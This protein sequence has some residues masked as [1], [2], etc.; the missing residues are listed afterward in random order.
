MFAVAVLGLPGVAAAA[1]CWDDVPTDLDGGGPDVVFGLPSYDLPGKPNAGAIVVFSNL[2]AK[3]AADPKSPSARTLLTADDFDG[4]E[5]QAGA[6]FGAAVSAWHDIADG[7]D[8]DDCSDLL[9]GAPGQ[10][11]LGQTG[12]GQVYW[13]GGSESGLGSLKAVYDETMAGAGGPEPGDGFGSTI[14]ANSWSTVAI[15]VPGRDV[16]ELEDAGRVIRLNWT[17]VDTDP[18]LAV[19]EQD[20]DGDRN[21]EAG[22]RFGEVLD[23][24]A[25]GDGDLL[26]VGIPHED[27]GAKVDAGAVELFSTTGDA[28]SMVTQSS[29]GAGGAAEAG[30][31]YGASVAHWWTFVNGPTARLAVGVPGEDIGSTVDAGMVSFATWTMPPTPEEPMPALEGMAE[32]QHQ[33]SPASQGPSRGATVMAPACWPA[34]SARTTVASTSS[35]VP[36]TRASARRGPPVRLSQ[37]EFETDASPSTGRNGLSWTQNSPGVAGNGETGDRFAARLSSVELTTP[38]DDTDLVWPVVLLTVPGEDVEGVVDAGMAYIG[39]APG[40]VSVP[41]NLPRQAGAGIGMVPMQ[42]FLF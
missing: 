19:V 22:D 14:A 11:V 37:T 39:Y 27:V 8:A 40:K 35:S 4:L 25:T 29:A 16:N 2:A 1:P 7:D 6:R 21:A 28:A 31:R 38:E 13:L 5:S 3:G 15:G 20:L 17:A 32:T 26:V 18:Y 9:V 42:D 33:N 36:P 23:L 12:A 30:D 24:L 41:L 34:S 10:N